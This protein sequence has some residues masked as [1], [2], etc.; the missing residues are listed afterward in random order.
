[1][2]EFLPKTMAWLFRSRCRES[3]TCGF[4]AECAR[5][6]SRSTVTVIGKIKPEDKGIIKIK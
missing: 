4:E 1:M 2:I 5:A 3:G 6:T